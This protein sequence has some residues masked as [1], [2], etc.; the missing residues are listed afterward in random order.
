MA[1]MPNF[2][3]SIKVQRPP[4]NSFDMSYDVKTTFDMGELIPVCCTEVL[5]GDSWTI[6]GNALVRFAPLI[7]PVMQ[8]MKSRIHYYFVPN[9]ILYEEG[10]WN[11]FIAGGVD[12]TAVDVPAAKL[13]V[14]AYNYADNPLFDYLHC[15][16]PGDT[17]YKV[18]ALPFAAYQAVVDQYYRDQNLQPAIPYQVVPG[19]QWV[20]TPTSHPLVQLRNCAWEHDLFTSALPS[21]QFGAAVDIPIGRGTITYDNDTARPGIWKKRDDGPVPDPLSSADMGTDSGGTVISIGGDGS[22]YNYDPNGTL[23]TEIEPTTINTLRRAF[24]L[25]RWAETAMRVGRRLTEVVMGH[26]GVK[27]SDARLQ[28]PEYIVGVSAPIIISEVLNTTGETDGLPQGNMAGHA[29]GVSDGQFGN[30]FAEEHGWI[31]GLMSVVPETSYMQGVPNHFYRD[32][33]FDYFWP[34]LANIGEAAIPMKEV[35]IQAEDR[36]APFG[37]M[38]QYYSYRFNQSRVSGQ[39]KTNLDYWHFGRKFEEEPALNEDF[40][41]CRPRKNPFAVQSEDVDSLYVHVYNQM[42]AVRLVNKYG[43][44]I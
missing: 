2:L 21:A 17:P 30:F 40:I 36:D 28:R 18:S 29:L 37:F 25:Q 7:A 23:T 12:G 38:P 20:G 3:N 24:S 26:F 16:D 33:K 31:I 1:K 22:Q 8:K 34:E 35:F 39:F 5:P 44:P 19:D 10:V 6:G 14:G 11:E 4:R 32:D 15:P 13:E 43:T 41:L 27:S 9:R 42:R